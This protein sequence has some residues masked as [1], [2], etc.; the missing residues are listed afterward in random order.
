MGL[1]QGSEEVKSLL[2]LSDYSIRADRPFEVLVDMEAQELK[3]G[4]STSSL[5]II[6]DSLVSP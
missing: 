4:H 2:G 6:T 1:H 5:P 3:A